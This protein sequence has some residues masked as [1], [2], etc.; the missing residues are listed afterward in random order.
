MGAAMNEQQPAPTPQ[1]EPAPSTSPSPSSS[2]A[3][4]TSSPSSTPSAQC[5]PDAPA[6]R[7]AA[8]DALALLKADHDRV[9]RLLRAFDAL[10]GKDDDDIDERKAELIDDICAELTIHALIEEEIFYPALRAA[11]ADDA[12]LDEAEGE[13]DGMR[14]LVNQLEVMYPGDDRFAATVVVLAEELGQHIAKEE[15]ELFKAARRAGIDLGSL[16]LRLAA[17]RHALEVD[18]TAPPAP[19]AA[20]EAGAARDGASDAGAGA[21]G[22][23]AGENRRE[24]REAPHMHDGVRRAPRAPN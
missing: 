22:A 10:D 12:L 11:G 15:G 1:A 17:R 8:P 20:R 2:P 5:A 19:A 18:M 14:E 3:P 9:A 13:H 7:P 6:S 21:A 4:T 23:L 16:G 24:A